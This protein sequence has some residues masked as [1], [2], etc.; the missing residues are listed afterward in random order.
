M[1]SIVLHQKKNA[2]VRKYD[3]E[4]IVWYELKAGNISTLLAWS[5]VPKFKVRVLV[6]L[7]RGSFA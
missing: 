5:L 3:D 4:K 6:A 2:K 1:S 7:Y